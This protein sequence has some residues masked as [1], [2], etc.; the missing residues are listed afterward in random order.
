[1]YVVKWN[2]ILQQKKSFLKNVGQNYSEVWKKKIV[3][4]LGLQKWSD[5]II[6]IFKYKFSFNWAF[7]KG[8]EQDR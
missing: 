4:F 3:L 2:S 5:Q 8:G 6:G 1:M 7:Q